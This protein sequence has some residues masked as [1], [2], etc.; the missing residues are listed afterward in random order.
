MTLPLGLVSS[1]DD[2]R[3]KIGPASQHVELAT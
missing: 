1:E 2:S 3:S